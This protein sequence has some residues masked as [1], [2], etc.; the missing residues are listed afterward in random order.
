MHLRHG[1]EILRTHKRHRT[2][3][4]LQFVKLLIVSAILYGLMFFIGK[5]VEG[6]WIFWGYAVV[7]FFLGIAIT[8]VAF[9]YLLDRL[10]IT[11]KRVVWINWKSPVKREEH[12]AELLDIQDIKTHE[13]GILSKLRL[14]DYG[15]LEIETAGSKTCI[16]FTE[17]PDPENVKTFILNQMEK[18]RGG[19]H[20]KWEPPPKDEE[21]SVN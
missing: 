20:E 6:D 12:E 13:K 14:F 9:D 16:I 19:I 7:S 15:L 11:N 17:C 10:V 2:P 5:A 1:E 8:L 18:Q 3:F 21:W 4:I